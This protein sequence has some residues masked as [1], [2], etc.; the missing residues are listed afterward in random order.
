MAYIQCE[1]MYENSRWNVG[2]RRAA[3]ATNHEAKRQY[4]AL[5]ADKYRYV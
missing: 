3:S 2:K 5:Q 1:G 4:T